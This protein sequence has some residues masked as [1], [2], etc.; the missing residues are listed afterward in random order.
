MRLRQ[1]L[2]I[3][4]AL[5]VAAEATGALASAGLDLDTTVTRS[6]IQQREGLLKGEYDVAMTAMDNVFAWN[7]LP[8]GDFRIIGQVER[9]TYMPI[10]AQAAIRSVDDLSGARVL[11]DAPDS[12][13]VMALRYI[14]ET[15]GISRADYSLAPVGGVK[16]RLEALLAGEGDVGLL[17]PPFDETAKAAGLNLIG[18]VADFLP[19]YPGQGLIVRESRM[20]ELLPALSAYAAALEAGLAWLGASRAEALESLEAAGFA[21]QSAPM[22]LGSAPESLTP[23]KGGIS[24][25]M[26]V[27]RA[28]GALPQPEPSYADITNLRPLRTGASQLA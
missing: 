9:A 16:E 24:T 27:R 26:D 21:A 23:A 15:R 19:L 11:V 10:Y 5:L 3:K 22:V 1:I 4:P 6:S 14:M 12:G 20:T 8:G 13:Y 25:M 18:C 7:A 17:S 28:L 2:F